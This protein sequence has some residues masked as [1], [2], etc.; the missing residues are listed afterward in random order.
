[1]QN[2]SAIPDLLRQLTD[3]D[4]G[5]RA[6]VI[7]ALGELRADSAIPLFDAALSDQ[8]ME[9]RLQALM[10]LDRIGQQP[11]PDLL[12]KLVSL[13]DDD[14]AG[15]RTQAAAML[16]RSGEASRAMPALI[17]WLKGE[18]PPHRLEALETIKRAGS[19]LHDDMDPRLIID[20]VQDPFIQIQVAA[21]EALAGFRD[22]AGT[23]ALLECL[24]N[25]NKSVRK[26]ASE[27][28]RDMGSAVSPLLLDIL[29]SGNESAR[30]AALDAITPED[31]QVTDRL[32]HYAHE[33]IVRLRALRGQIATLPAIGRAVTL[34]LAS[35]HSQAGANET[36]LVKIVGL[37]GN[38]RTMELV[39]KSLRGSDPQTRAAALE[40]LETMGDK[41]LTREIVS[42]LEEE[43]VR[44]TPAEVIGL[45]LENG[46]RWSRA[47]AARAIHEL[48]LQEFIP[49]L[50]AMNTETDVLVQEAALDSLTLLGEVKPM[51]T[52]QTVSTL[53]RVLLLREIPI[54]A[55]LLPEDLEQV[56]RIAREQL[57]PAGTNI[58]KQGEQGNMMFVIV[59]GHVHVVHSTKDREQVLAQ[60]G[61]GDFV[62]EMAIIESA[63]RSATLLT[64]SEVRVLAIEGEIFKGILRE[65]PD[66][67][68]AVLQSIS[69][70]LREMNE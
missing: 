8:D 66:V 20:L 47:L 3:P 9:V 23:Q 31:V 6:S 55:D 26:A 11:A 65:R 17:S 7:H 62:G 25:E 39:Q 42:L 37:I 34:L 52:L 40:A 15:L 12:N 10:A 32:R 16:F 54:F 14:S 44:S 61:P 57:Y 22:P 18:E 49:Q 50:A 36:R 64:R 1:M 28:L 13:L 41:T 56:A 38:T 58:F 4:A 29:A 48:D 19:Y 43:P 30:D 53:E 5:V 46:P 59:S 69:R 63:P 33:E 45:I 67:S 27:S 24:Q 2:S 35:L 68:L 70:R 60:R 51:D 21:C